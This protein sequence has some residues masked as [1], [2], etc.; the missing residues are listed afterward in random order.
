MSLTLQAVTVRRGARALLDGV[1]LVMQPGRVTALCGPNG[2]GKSTALGVLSGALRP[3]SGHAAL[4]GVPLADLEPQALA[5]RRAVL[6]Q[7]PSLN[8]PF[9]AHEVVAIGRTPHAG[10]VEGGRDRAIIAAAMARTDVMALA[11][12]NYLTLSG[13]ERQRVQLARALAQIWDPP[14]DRAARWLLLDEPTAALDLKHQIRLMHLLRALADEGWG[15]V[16]VLHDLRLVRAHAD[17][18]VLLSHGCVAAAGAAADML[19]PQRIQ[20]VFEL[21]SPYAA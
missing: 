1:D 11:E 18:V 3:T 14:A 7:T 2:A 21:D 8:F 5:R 16:A 4:D 19:T 13:G 12:R 15:V 10:Q 6:P 17:D 9:L 20:E